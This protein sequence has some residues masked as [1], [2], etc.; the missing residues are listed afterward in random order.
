MILDD[1]NVANKAL[2]CFQTHSDLVGWKINHAAATGEYIFFTLAA[3][4]FSK[5]EDD[6]ALPTTG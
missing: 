1:Y 3:W 5:P 2:G 6:K 4:V